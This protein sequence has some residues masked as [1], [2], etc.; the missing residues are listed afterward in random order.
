MRDAVHAID[1]DQPVQSLGSMTSLIS[2]TIAEPL[3]QARLLAVFS[4]CALFLAA[5]GIYGVLAYAVTERTREI[6]IRVAVGASS[7]AVVRMV[8]GRTFVL[9]IAGIAVGWIVSLELTHV[10]SSLLFH[11]KPTDPATFGLVG[12]LLF[13]V[14]LVATI[15]PARRATRVDPLIALR[16]E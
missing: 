14:A 7:T 2:S 10:L 5:I 12:A 13:L 3:F 15:I 16:N 11:T 1:I 4:L 8:V 9:A 6:G